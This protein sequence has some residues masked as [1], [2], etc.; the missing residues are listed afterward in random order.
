CGVR[1]FWVF[2][3]FVVGWWC[4]VVAGFVGF[5][6]VGCVV[7]VVF[8]GLVVLLVLGCLWFVGCGVCGLCGCCCCCVCGLC[9]G[10]GCF[11]WVWCWDG[12]C[13]VGAVLR[14]YWVPV[15]CAG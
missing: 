7:V 4:G 8:G 5:V 1:V 14:V 3:V 13:S 12:G 6:G 15:W 2:G 9:V 10:G 11:G